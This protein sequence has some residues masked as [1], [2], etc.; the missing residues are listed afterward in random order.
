LEAK[1][2]HQILVDLGPGRPKAQRIYRTAGRHRSL[3]WLL[4][5]FLVATLVFLA[6]LYLTEP[7]LLAYCLRKGI[8]CVPD[9]FDRVAY[10]FDHLLHLVRRFLT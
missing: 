5:L 1:I 9:R 10:W 2:R 4:A 6:M 3:L 7:R 8:Y